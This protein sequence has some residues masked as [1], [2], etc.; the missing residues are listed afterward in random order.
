M[1]SI[2]MLQYVLSL[3]MIITILYAMYAGCKSSRDYGHTLG[4][5]MVG[6]ISA[7]VMGWSPTVYASTARTFTFLFMASIYVSAYM[8]KIQHAFLNNY[9]K[10]SSFV[11]FAIV[12]RTMF[13]VMYKQ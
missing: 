3:C 7:M 4:V 1:M 12:I 6:L 5:W 8:L 11:C 9:I 13:F 2:T 10:Y